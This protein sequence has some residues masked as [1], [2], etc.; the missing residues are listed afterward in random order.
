M[1]CPNLTVQ[2]PHTPGAGRNKPVPLRH[3]NSLPRPVGCELRTHTTNHA[4]FPAT[5]GHITL[6][7]R[8]NHLHGSPFGKGA[9]SI[10][11]HPVIPL[12]TRIVDND[13][14]SRQLVGGVADFLQN[15]ICCDRFNV[16]AIHG[17]NLLAIGTGSDHSLHSRVDELIEQSTKLFLEKCHPSQIVGRFQTTPQPNTQ[18]R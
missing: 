11:R 13:I 18:L 6:I 10:L 17:K 14:A 8:G 3:F 1:L 5:A 15:F 16:P 4:P 7:H 9:D 2:E 12:W